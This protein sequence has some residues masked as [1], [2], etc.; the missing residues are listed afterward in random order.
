M[1]R[2]S[3]FLIAIF[4]MQSMQAQMANF[5]NWTNYSVGSVPLNIPTMWHGLDSSIVFYGSFLNPGAPFYSQIEKELPGNGSATALKVVTKNQS[6]LTGIIPAGPFPSLASNAV[7][8]VNTSTGGFD[9]FGGWTY[10]NNPLNASMYVK[11]A[12]VSGDSTKITLL[13]IDNSDGGDSIAAIADTMLGATI[14]TWTKITLPFHYN[15]SGFNTMLI[16][17]LVTSSGNFGTDTTTG[18]FTGLHD[19]TALMVDDI[20]IAAPNG[21]TQY[22]YSSKVACIYPTEFNDKIHINLQIKEQGNYSLRIYDLHG[23]MIKTLPILD[24]INSFNVSD[25]HLGTYLYVLYKDDK[26]MQT[27]K[28][29]KI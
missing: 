3:L 17:V 10:L 1:K 27:G 24:L 15:P 23:S 14:S 28:L 29:T 26:V 4:L 20:D 11:N 22:V 7:I 21:V 19:G 6:A 5:E 8:T 9:L 13:A 25:L 16:R 2:V 18:S 12:P